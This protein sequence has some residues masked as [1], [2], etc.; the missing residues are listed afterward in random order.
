MPTLEKV[1]EQ[2]ILMMW[3]ALGLNLTFSYAPTQELMMVH[4][5]EMLES[6][7]SWWLENGNVLSP[8]IHSFQVLSV[9]RTVSGFRMVIPYWKGELKSALE[10]NGG[11]CVVMDGILM[12]L[13]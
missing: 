11:L 2:S 5:V 9:L 4:T 3:N 10:A 7:V 6:D 13:K 1:L 8:A 12:M